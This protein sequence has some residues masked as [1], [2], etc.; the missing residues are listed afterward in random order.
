MGTITAP[1]FQVQVRSS[2]EARY[3]YYQYCISCKQT[4]LN[5]SLSYIY[6]YIYMFITLVASELYNFWLII[7]YILV[8]PLCSKLQSKCNYSKVHTSEIQ[9]ILLGPR[10][11]PRPNIINWLWDSIE[12]VTSWDRHG[13]LLD[14]ANYSAFAPS[15]VYEFVWMVLKE[16]MITKI[17]FNFAVRKEHR[18][19]H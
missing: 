14:P 6:I 19:Q 16:L 9:W 11:W 2:L 13:C 4:W 1:T 7:L 5:V 12:V 18:S 15:K 3:L 17:I 8:G 10:N